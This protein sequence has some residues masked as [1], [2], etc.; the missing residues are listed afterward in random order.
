MHGGLARIAMFAMFGL[1]LSSCSRRGTPDIVVITLDTVRAD[2]LGCY[3]NRLSPTPHIDRFAVRA[4]VFEDASCA[5]PLTLPS[6]ATIF[7]GRYPTATGVRNNGTFVLPGSETTLA[8]MLLARGWRTGAVIAAFPLHSRFGLA[9]GFDIYDEELPPTPVGNSQG[10]SV[11]FNERDAHAV[12][13]R[14]LAVWARLTGGP[15]FLWVHYFDAHAPYAAPEPWGSAHAEH[16]YD[17]EIAYVDSEV[18]RLLERIERDAADAVI[19]VAGDHGE[20]LGD[21]GE[22]THGVFLYQSTVQVPLVIRAPGRWPTGKRVEE[23]VTLAD[24]VPTILALTGAPTP[25]GLDGADL[26]PAVAGTRSPAR[27]VYAESYLPRL[28]FRFSPLTMLRNGPL[29]Y[30][31]APTVELYDVRQDPGESHNLAGGH[32]EQEPMAARLLDVVGR[33]DPGAGRRAEG[34]LDAD[35]EARLRSLGYASAGTTD[36]PAQ[37]RG[38]DPKTMTMYLQRYDHA[39]GLT[40][41]GRIDEG[42]AE[43]RELLPEAPENYMA[44]YQVAAA[45]LAAGRA[46]DARVELEQVVAVAPEFGNAHWMLAEC[47]GALGLTDDAARRFETAVRLMPNQAGPRL[48]EGRA[49]EARGRFDAAAQSYRAAIGSEPT[50]AEGVKALL[51]LRASRGDMPNAAREL[52]ELATRFP[53]SVAL[54]TGLAE[55]ESRQGNAGAAA[56]ALRRALALD[57]EHAEARLLQ[58]HLLLDE[59]RPV[60]A[61]TAYRAVLQ[62]RPGLRAAELGLGRALVLGSQDA[63]A[64]EWIARL[65]ARYPRDPAPCV[66]RGVLFERRRDSAAA[67]YAYREALALDP[68]NVDA[69]SGLDRIA[70]TR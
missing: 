15:R 48:A 40:S 18:G 19:V 28:Q 22:K 44:R 2:R 6:H 46:G 33:G 14:A 47:Y 27:E 32:A 65:T 50:S 25:S 45:L 62:A 67:L 52:G 26:A 57:P 53:G 60:D 37:G 51:A 70:R 56:A 63:E 66:L 39:V 9:Q 54:Q 23:P 61:A 3:G 8:E 21:H 34:T 5:V 7:T 31:D 13:D 43:L 4:V 11:H 20:G 68:R 38:R 10:F 12:T 55:A 49:L 16:R 69:R 35:S 29:K 41:S 36:G 17:G 24:L 42:L 1:E 58:A 30:V 59:G 64:E